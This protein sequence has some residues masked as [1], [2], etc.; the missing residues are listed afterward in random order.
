MALAAFLV[1]TVP[2]HEAWPARELLLADEV[3]VLAVPAAPAKI[4]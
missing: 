1:P 4:Q 3:P 2:N